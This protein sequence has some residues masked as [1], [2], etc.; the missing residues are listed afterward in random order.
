LG[1]KVMKKNARAFDAPV[2]GGKKN[3]KIVC[4][5]KKKKERGWFF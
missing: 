1:E 5:W 4:S 2:S 3:D